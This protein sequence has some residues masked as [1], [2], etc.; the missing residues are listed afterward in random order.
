MFLPLIQK[1]R[2]IRQFQNKAVEQEKIEIITEAMLRAPSSRGINPWEF[3]LIDRPEMMDYLSKTKKH[4]SSFLKNAPFAIII[5]A[6]TQKSDVWVEDTSITAT[7]IQ[8]AAEDIGLSSCWIQI[9]NRPHDES[10][11][12]RDYIAEYLKIPDQYQVASI[13]AIGYADESKEA[14]KKEHLQTEK[15]HLNQ[16]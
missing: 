3:I 13:I 14:H 12:G 15:I 5:L 10:R 1:R 8:L 7:Y 9:R 11:S 4:G 16:Y 2:S 6:D